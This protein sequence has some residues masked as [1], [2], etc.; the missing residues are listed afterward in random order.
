MDVPV[1]PLG[2]SAAITGASKPAATIRI[3]KQAPTRANRFRMNGE[4]IDIDGVARVTRCDCVRES[5]ASRLVESA[6][7]AA[8]NLIDDL[9]LV[10]GQLAISHFS[11]LP[12]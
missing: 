1:L 9:L 8:A 4:T 11:R 5:L 7:D 2:G 10:I 3:M 6:V 12:A